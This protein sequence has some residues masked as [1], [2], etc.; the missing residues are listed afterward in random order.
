MLFYKSCLDTSHGTVEGV[1]SLI[2]P[3]MKVGDTGR[4]KNR[5]YSEQNLHEWQNV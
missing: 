1:K 5:D 4:R 3:A 2:L